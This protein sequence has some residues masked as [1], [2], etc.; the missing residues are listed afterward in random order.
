[1]VCLPHPQKLAQC[2]GQELFVDEARPPI[3]NLISRNYVPGPG[4]RNQLAGASWE[5][6]PSGFMRKAKKAFLAPSVY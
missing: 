1:M 3:S 2:L 5:G 6:L 4:A